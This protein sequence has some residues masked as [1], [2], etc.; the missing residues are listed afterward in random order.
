M[1]KYLIL[2]GAPEGL[3]AL[4]IAKAVRK[5]GGLHLHIAR[6]ELRLSAMLEALRFFDPALS[7][8]SFPAWDCLPYDRVSPKPEVV[9][10]RMATLS[11]LTGARAGPTVVVTTVSGALQRVPPRK[12]VAGANLRV[13]KGATLKLD[14]LLLFL[15]HNGFARSGAVVEPGDFAVR[16]GIV[17]IY[18]PGQEQ[19]VRLDYFGDVIESI[20]KFDPESQTSIGDIDAVTLS[21]VNEV[22]ID[23]ESVQRFRAGYVATFGTVL[24]DDPL[25]E[26][27]SS[28]RKHPGMEHW[29]PL[30]HAQLETIFDYVGAAPV[31]LDHQVEE[32]HASRLVLIKDY[33]DARIAARETAKKI[34][35]GMA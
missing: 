31:T 16:G 18:P 4:L 35:R 1:S 9:A 22:P 3:D 11:A 33:Y 21:P 2:A 26:S 29:L 30:F 13:V 32:S 15:A 7:V 10:E 34:V 8:L 14:E 17:D 25:Y 28:Y 19:P 23:K 12:A 20:R 27:V 24:D 5:S 6:D